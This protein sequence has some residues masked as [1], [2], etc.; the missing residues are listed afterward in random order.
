MMY[1]I[2]FIQFASSEGI[3]KYVKTRFIKSSVEFV[4]LIKKIKNNKTRTVK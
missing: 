1:Y 2:L 4:K 3:I